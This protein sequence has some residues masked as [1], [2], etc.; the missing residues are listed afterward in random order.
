MRDIWK[1]I[2]L[3]HIITL[4]FNSSG[5]AFVL[6][7]VGNVSLSIYYLIKRD[8]I[9]NPLSIKMAGLFVSS[10]VIWCLGVWYWLVVQAG[11]RPDASGDYPVQEVPGHRLPSKFPD[12]PPAQYR[13]LDRTVHGVC[14]LFMTN[15]IPL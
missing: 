9:Q 7:I 4:L 3:E 1:N 10:V 11:G 2:S 6:W 14:M 12:A 15:D 13:F 8:E 5:P